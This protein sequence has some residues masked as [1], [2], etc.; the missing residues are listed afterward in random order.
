M[1]NGNQIYC[2][3]FVMYRNIKSLCFAPGR[4]IVFG[5]NILQLKKK[6]DRTCNDNMLKSFAVNNIYIVIMMEALIMI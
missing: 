6:S 5:S 3:H 4:N 1:T 2:D